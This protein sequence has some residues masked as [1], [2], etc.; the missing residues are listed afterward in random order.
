LLFAFV[1]LR[2]HVALLGYALV[3]LTTAVLYL[4]ACDPLPPRAGRFTE[5]LRRRRTVVHESVADAGP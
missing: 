1:I 2:L 5:W 3:F 4:L